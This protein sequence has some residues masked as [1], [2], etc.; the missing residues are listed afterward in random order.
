MDMLVGG[1]L[2]LV[3]GLLHSTLLLVRL[4][5]AEEGVSSGPFHTT[6]QN[7]N[8]PSEAV[9]G[10]GHGLLHFLLGG[11]GGIRSEMLLGL[12]AIGILVSAE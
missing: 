5:S 11:L 9:S 10:V 6:L 12:C 7:C 2:A 3:E 8:L 4:G 1:A